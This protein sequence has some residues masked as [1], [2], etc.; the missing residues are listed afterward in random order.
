MFFWIPRNYQDFAVAASGKVGI[1]GDLTSNPFQPNITLNADGS[2]T[3][4]DDVVSGSN[5]ALSENNEGIVLRSRGTVTANRPSGVIYQGYTTG[6][7]SATYIV[8]AD[9]SI[10]A[11]GNVKIGGTL[12]AAPNISLNAANGNISTEGVISS[13]DFG[14]AAGKEGVYIWKGTGMEGQLSTYSNNISKGAILV[15][16]APDNLTTK[17]TKFTVLNSGE[18]RIGND[19]SNAGPVG[20]VNIRLYND[21]AGEFA[22]YLKVGLTGSF[23]AS[24]PAISL[25]PD[26]TAVFKDT[27]TVGPNSTSGNSVCLQN[28]KGYGALS[29]QSSSGAFIFGY[30]VK[31]AATDRHDFL[32]TVSNLNSVRVAYTQAGDI[33]N[34]FVNGHSFW[35]TD[36]RV[37]TTV[38]QPVDIKRKF[39][40][41]GA[42][43]DV[44]I[45]S[46][47]QSPGD[48]RHLAECGR[49]CI[50]CW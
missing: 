16:S 3:F 20:N 10:T 36:G 22:S 32:S 15:G 42:S 23:T 5:P 49:Q 7:S 26:G 1:G 33:S 24:T 2:A 38:D 31:G 46:D 47:L 44:Y 45:G 6:N 12:P 41:S 29:N 9:G 27:I 13:G 39:H 18:L 21:G 43:G 25:N 37:N 19:A 30:G 8:D 48:E 17:T 50:V 4:A 34:A 28:D 11:A 14:S 35:S 40:I